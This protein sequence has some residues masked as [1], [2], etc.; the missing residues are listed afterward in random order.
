MTWSIASSRISETGGEGGCQA[1][2]VGSSLS[3]VTVS[4]DEKEEGWKDQETGIGVGR[5]ERGP[6]T[7]GLGMAVA[8]ELADRRY[9]GREEKEEGRASESPQSDIIIDGTRRWGCGCG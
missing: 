1:R 2:A 6:L 8:G 5:R 7:G 4:G 9:T 3:G